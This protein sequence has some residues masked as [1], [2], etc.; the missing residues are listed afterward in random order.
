MRV[1]DGGSAT[2][3]IR[4]Q[5]P[6]ANNPVLRATPIIAVYTHGCRLEPTEAF[7]PGRGFD[8]RI[9]KPVQLSHVERVL[10]VRSRGRGLPVAGPGPGPGTVAMGAGAGAGGERFRSAWGYRVPKPLL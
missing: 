4:T 7:M 5:P 8:E 10:V 6:F 3:I 9:E 2:L 1:L